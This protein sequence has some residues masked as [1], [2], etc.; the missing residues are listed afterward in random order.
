MPLRT[1]N[2]GFGDGV[3]QRPVPAVS[4]LAL[5]SMENDKD[6]VDV[7]MHAHPDPHIMGPI[8]TAR[9]LKLF[10]LEGDCILPVDGHR[11]RWDLFI[12]CD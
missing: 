5:R 12:L 11:Y 8:A 3:S 4:T 7:P 9:D 2:R 6:L 1:V 10:A